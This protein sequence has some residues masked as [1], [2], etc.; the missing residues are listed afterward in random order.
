MIKYNLDTF[1]GRLNTMNKK[2]ILIILIIK[3]NKILKILDFL[4]I[5]Y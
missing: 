5:K 1:I 3:N 4:D 2:K